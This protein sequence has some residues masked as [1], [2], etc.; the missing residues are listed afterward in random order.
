VA[1]LDVVYHA[2]AG[3]T[4]SRVCFTFLGLG[5]ETSLMSRDPNPSEIP[6]RQGRV[7]R[8]RDLSRLGA[9]WDVN[10]LGL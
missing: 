3:K 8:F 5:K 9:G 10:L 6:C 7:E 2:W 1:A 4:H